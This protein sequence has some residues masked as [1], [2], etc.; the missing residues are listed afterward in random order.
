[1][2]A[3]SFTPLLTTLGL[4]GITGFL[5]GFAVKK[6][7][8]ILAVVAGLFF[9]VLMYLQSQGILNINWHKLQNISQPILSTFANNLNS[10]GLAGAKHTATIPNL[11]HNNLSF[12]PIDMGL[13]L[14][15]SAVLGFILGLTRG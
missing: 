12:L 14:T 7:M 10:T 5:V 13:P 15:G 9:A 1:M 4:G 3:D 2:I 8:K 11:V 6:I